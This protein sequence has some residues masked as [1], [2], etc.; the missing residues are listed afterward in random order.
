[1][2]VKSDSLKIDKDM[3]ML[4]KTLQEYDVSAYEAIGLMVYRLETL[5][6]DIRDGIEE[7]DEERLENLLSSMNKLSWKVM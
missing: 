4:L 2:K 5:L 7:E 6:E 3:M 1:M